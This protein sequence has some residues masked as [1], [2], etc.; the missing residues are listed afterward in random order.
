M[1][2]AEHFYFQVAKVPFLRDLLRRPLNR[3]LKKDVNFFA[4]I[5]NAIVHN[6]LNKGFQKK[7]FWMQFLSSN[8]YVKSLHEKKYTTPLFS[9][10]FTIFQWWPVPPYTSAR[11][12]VS[13]WPPVKTCCHIGLKRP[14]RGRKCWIKWWCANRRKNL[15]WSSNHISTQVAKMAFT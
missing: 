7:R 4:L 12:V 3:I 15:K 8:F 1:V 11:N 2:R 6:F 10:L 13:L 9:C 14:R 5:Q